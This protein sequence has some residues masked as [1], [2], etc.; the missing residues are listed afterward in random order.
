MLKVSRNSKIYLATTTKRDKYFYLANSEYSS[1][2][3]N[4]YFMLEDEDFGLNYSSTKYCLTDIDPNI[5]RE[6][7]VNNFSFTTLSYYAFQAPKYIK[8]Y[9]FKISNSSTYK[10]SIIYYEG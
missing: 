4:I 6:S 1:Y 10:Y 8:K 2:S 3:S 9:Y 7:A 5:Y